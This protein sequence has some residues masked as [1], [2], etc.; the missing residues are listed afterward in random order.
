MRKLAAWED[1][2]PENGS[3][4]SYREAVNKAQEKSE[5]AAES[6]KDHVRSFA[7]NKQKAIQASDSLTEGRKTSAQARVSRP[8]GNAG[9]GLN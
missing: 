1:A 9:G 3:P 5:N 7:Q 8:K 4:G 6:L 2:Y